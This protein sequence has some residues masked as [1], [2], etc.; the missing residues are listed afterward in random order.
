MYYK[1]QERTKCSI[2]LNNTFNE[3]INKIHEKH[4]TKYNNKTK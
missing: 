3:L 2:I 1:L 4:F